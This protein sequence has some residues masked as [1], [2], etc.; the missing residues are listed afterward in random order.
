MT[1]ELDHFIVF[2]A[3]PERAR[4]ALVER[5]L[6]VGHEGSQPGTGCGHT[7]FF[8]DNTYL[9]LVWSEPGKVPFADAPRMHATDRL[10][11]S[12][13]CPLGISFRPIG[14]DRALPLQTWDYAAPFLPDGATS[15]RNSR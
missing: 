13:W 9:E 15:G 14:S 1:F 6:E 10:T 8:F 11:S 5:G 3:G 12:Q 2:V 7:V 4:S